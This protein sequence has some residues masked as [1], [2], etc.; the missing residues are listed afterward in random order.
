MH[1]HKAAHRHIYFLHAYIPLLLHIQNGNVYCIT[2]LRG[3]VG[4]NRV[5][6]I[7]IKSPKRTT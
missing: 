6:T 3:D 4:Y 2:I 5:A 1:G 7:L